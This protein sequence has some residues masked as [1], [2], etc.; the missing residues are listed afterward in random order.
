[1]S[2]SYSPSHPDFVVE[3]KSGEFASFLKTCR[4]FAQGETLT[5]LS[6]LTRCPKAYSSVQCGRG[7]ED[8]VELNSDFV[9]V[10]HSCEPNIVFDLSSA[11]PSEWHVRTLKDIEV[12][13]PVTFF[14]PSTEWDMD[15]AFDCRCGTKSCLGRI[16]GA[17]YLTV[18][19]LLRHGR[20]ANPWIPELM[21]S[22]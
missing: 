10:N 9:F 12:G 20:W 8:N 21:E 22:K 17:K 2:V 11:D 14:Y 15:Q 6:N 4:S 5:V 16:Q 19:E 1:M 7:P 3:F 13:S 18:E